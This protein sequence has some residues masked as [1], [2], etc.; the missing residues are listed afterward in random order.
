[1]QYAM[2]IN[3]VPSLSPSKWGLSLY[4]DVPILSREIALKVLSPLRKL[5]PA[6][7]ATRNVAAR[8]VA[9]L[10]S[11]DENGGRHATGWHCSFDKNRGTDGRLECAPVGW[12]PTEVYY[13]RFM[14]DICR[15]DEEGDIAECWK[16]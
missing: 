6:A 16:L 3:A 13:K 15:Y 9:H 14:M 4:L 1:M 5:F 7:M 2:V 10:H 11:R 12:P 8:D